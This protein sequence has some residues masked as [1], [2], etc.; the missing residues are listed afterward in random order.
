M[1]C[2]FLLIDTAAGIS[3]NVVEMLA[4]SERVLIVTSLEPTAVVDAYALIKVLTHASIR[5]RIS[6]SSSTTRETRTKRA[7]SSVSSTSRRR[8]SSTAAS[9]RTASSLDD[10]A[11]RESVLRPAAGRR[12][13]T[14][15]SP[16]SR[17]FR[18]LASRVAGLRPLQRARSAPVPRPVTRPAPDT[19]LEAP[20]CA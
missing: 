20:Q 2:D 5:R 17:C 16:A 19:D 10:P 11:V 8:A 3:D 15:Q 7:S 6:A 9:L 1:S 18:M 12:S 4:G 13:T 14:P